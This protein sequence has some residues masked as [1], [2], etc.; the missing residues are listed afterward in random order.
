MGC[1]Q[2]QAGDTLL[3][4]ENQTPFLAVLPSCRLAVLPSCRLAVLSPSRLADSPVP[5]RITEAAPRVG[6]L[7]VEDLVAGDPA[8]AALDAAFIGEDRP[9]VVSRDVAVRRAAVDALLANAV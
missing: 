1:C 8:G 6:P 4:A 5:I 9:P 3:Q 7:D 2:S